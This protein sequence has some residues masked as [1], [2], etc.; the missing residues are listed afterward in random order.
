M[1]KK[2]SYDWVKNYVEIDSRS[3]CRL[4]STTYGNRLK[5]LE[6]QCK[7]G[8]EFQTS[9]DKFIQRNKRQCNGCGF[10]KAR[11]SKNLKIEDV[12]EEINSKSTSIL[13]SERYENNSSLLD[14]VC[15]CGNLYKASL[16]NIRNNNY[17]THCKECRY[18]MVANSN[19]LDR[20]EFIKLL[21]RSRNN[22]YGLIEDTIK[23]SGANSEAEFIHKYNNCNYIFATKACNM[24]RKNCPYDCPKC[25]K[26]LIKD[27]SNNINLIE[28]VEIINNGKFEITKYINMQNTAVVKHIEND[29]NF[30]RLVSLKHTKYVCGIQSC[31]R[32]DHHSWKGGKTPI[33]T[34]IRDNLKEWK[35]KSSRNSNFE[36]VI[37]KTKGKN[38]LV[39][40]HLYS[41]DNI[42]E[43]AFNDI[44]VFPKGEINN[45]CKEELEQL[46]QRVI[47]IHNS[48]PLGVLLRKDIHL[49]FHKIY[50]YGNNTPEQFE[51][52]K[53]RYLLNEF[54]KTNII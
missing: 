42:L 7:C 50:G 45:Y 2:L 8:N 33:G 22:H 54:N 21:K 27:K 4:L 5:I 47:E 16:S 37:T 32:C 48:L 46:L 19:R 23:F 26:N 29:C 36:C 41:F 9:L 1:G 24:I 12:R 39:L 43:Q 28:S 6:F 49:L 18:S 15:Q 44:M 13:I 35:F 10:K 51:E 38:K 31:T 14:L 11:S 20:K 3:G 25:A 53:Y 34:Y 52:F 40:H 17:S 30:E